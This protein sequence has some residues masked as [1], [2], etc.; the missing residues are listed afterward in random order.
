MGREDITSTL[1]RVVG[2]YPQKCITSP[3]FFLLKIY[4]KKTQLGEGHL[5]LSVLRAGE[6]GSRGPEEALLHDGVGVTAGCSRPPSPSCAAAA[7]HEAQRSHSSAPQS[8]ASRAHC[9][10]AAAQPP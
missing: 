9:P 4:Y 1:R 7:G 2:A 6:G 10:F 3:L 8:V 5:S